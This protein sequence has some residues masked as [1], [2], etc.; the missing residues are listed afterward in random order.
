MLL[1]D[2]PIEILGALAEHLHNIE[3]FNNLISTC[4]SL[5]TTLSQTR[6][7]VIL[8]L[9]SRS[10]PTFFSPH[11]YFLTATTARGAARAVIGNHNLTNDL[12]QALLS[13][14]DGLY[15]FCL[16]HSG[17]T[18]EGIRKWH[19][20]RFST[21]NPLSDRIDKM[22]GQQWYETPN[23]WNG[24]VSDAFTLNTDA[25]RCAYQIIIYGELF[26]ESMRSFLQPQLSLPYFGP[27]T[28]IEYIKYCVPD[29]IC[30]NG[31]YPGMETQSKVGPYTKENMDSAKGSWGD[32]VA[33]HHVLG[34]GRWRRM[35]QEKL[36]QVGPDFDDTEMDTY[37]RDMARASTVEE[38]RQS[39]WWAAAI[40]CGGLEGLSAVTTTNEDGS[41][42]ADASQRLVLMRRYIEELD[43]NYLRSLLEKTTSF[44]TF[45]QT[46]IAVHPDFRQ[47]VAY[48]CRGMWPGTE[49]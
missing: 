46:G 47:E 4:R 10:A 26:E 14:I 39:L 37:E 22:A 48:C 35:W 11:P 34:C 7:Q 12:H 16:K 13:G 32:Q 49:S 20:A 9:A 45:A 3:D 24:G 29:W 25:D 19:L 21:I 17:I 28:R 36:R 2:L 40:E 38:M 41:L 31:G 30:A 1:L 15:D 8:Q 42:S 5:R 6:P 44:G 43:E 33:L 18:L 23:F 27:E